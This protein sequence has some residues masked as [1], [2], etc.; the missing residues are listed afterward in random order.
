MIKNHFYRWADHWAVRLADRMG[1]TLARAKPLDL[2]GCD[3]HPLEAYYRAGRCQPVLMDVPV[4]KL[5]GLGSAAFPCTQ[6]SGHPF[7]QTLLDYESGKVRS[8]AGSALESFYE[9][10][11]PSNAAEY[12]GVVNM[13][14]CEKL[15]ELKA[16]E[17]VL[18]WSKHGISERLENVRDAVLLAS[19]A[20]HSQID[21]RQNRWHFFGPATLESGR[22]EHERLMGVYSS[23]KNSGY[24]RNDSFDG[25]I[26]GSLLIDENEWCVL[27]SGGGQHRCCALSALGCFS[28]PV[29][30]FF[31][32]PMTV[33]KC[34]FYYWPHVIDGLFRQEVALSIFDRLLKGHPPWE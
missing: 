22:H 20:K 1:V 27:I 5:R 15:L 17:V 19:R 12:L 31:S 29:R 30:L 13:A 21:H 2:R 9:Q 25:D 18:P 14:G 16:I 4:E 11:Q 6:D 23:I 28:I 24:R 26:R 10:W 34:D 7:I 32:I 3:I 33:R 8:Y